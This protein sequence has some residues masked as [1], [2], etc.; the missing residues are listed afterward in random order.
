MLAKIIDERQTDA[1]T[2]HHASTTRPTGRLWTL[3]EQQTLKAIQLLD[4]P[5]DSFFGASVRLWS[6]ILQRLPRQTQK[7]LQERLLEALAGLEDRDETL[8]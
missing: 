4:Q 1:E 6:W 8:I 5:R 7:M 2:G 3:L